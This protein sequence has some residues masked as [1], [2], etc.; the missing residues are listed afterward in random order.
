MTIRHVGI[1]VTKSFLW[2]VC[3]FGILVVFW[4]LSAIVSPVT[5]WGSSAPQRGDRLTGRGSLRLKPSV[6]HP[7]SRRRTAS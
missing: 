3:V 6:P 4:F 5:P 1:I 2:V 7:Q